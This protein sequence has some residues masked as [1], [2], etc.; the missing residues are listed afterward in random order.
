MDLN[1]CDN[2]RDITILSIPRKVFYRLFLKWIDG[3]IDNNNNGA[4]DLK[5]RREQAGFQKG[6]GCKDR[7]FALLN[8][9][10]QCIE[11][12]VPLFFNST[13][14]HSAVTRVFRRTFMGHTEF[15][16]RLL[17]SPGNFVNTSMNCH[18]PEYLDKASPSSLAYDS[19][20]FPLQSCF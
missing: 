2:W 3:A 20:E 7:V 18:L 9:N 1:N 6:G 11:W 4:I 17:S 8:I 10:E 13:F 14:K 19:A 5:F 12:N 15:Q 16:P